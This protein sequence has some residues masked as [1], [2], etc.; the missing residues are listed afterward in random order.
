MHS[1]RRGNKKQTARIIEEELVR[2]YEQKEAKEMSKSVFDH[3]SI[4]AFSRVVNLDIT[5]V[6][7][8]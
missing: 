5:I 2:H 7:K 3:F 6:R 8:H 1:K 4:S